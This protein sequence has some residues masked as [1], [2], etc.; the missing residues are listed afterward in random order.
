MSQNTNPSS[1]KQN[2]AHKIGNTNQ[3]GGAGSDFSGL[4]YSWEVSPAELS[5][6]TLEKIDCAPMF[7]PLRKGTVIPTGTSGIIPAGVYL[8]ALPPLVDS[9]ATVECFNR[10]Q[11]G[12]VTDAQQIALQQAVAV[13]RLRDQQFVRQLAAQEGLPQQTGV[14]S[15]NGL[16]NSLAQFMGM[17]PYGPSQTG[18]GQAQQ[19]PQ[20]GGN[21]RTIKYVPST[22][23]KNTMTGGCCGSGGFYTGS[24]DAIQFGGNCAGCSIT[25][26]GTKTS[27][28]TMAQ[29]AALAQQQHITNM[30]TKQKGGT[31]AI[32]TSNAPF[33][34]TTTLGPNQVQQGGTL[35]NGLGY[36]PFVGSQMTATSCANSC[37]PF[38]NTCNAFPNINTSTT[39]STGS[40]PPGIPGAKGRQ[41]VYYSETESREGC[42]TRCRMPPGRYASSDLGCRATAF[43][44]RDIDYGTY[45]DLHGTNLAAS[46]APLPQACIRR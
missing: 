9:C 40:T 14:V 8:A 6:V 4:W 38:N 25:G 36:S 19:Q 27:H 1:Q 33:G 28:L 41:P 22:Q 37:V 17:N 42:T 5:R 2:Q 39:L 10:G 7:N 32:V 23:A 18:S 20:L 31:C 12:L 29:K 26:G 44:S 24:E 46:A 45:D 3:V 16:I 13:Q 43:A 30:S 15:D 34:K 11:V 21:A 35:S